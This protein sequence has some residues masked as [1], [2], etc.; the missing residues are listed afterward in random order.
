MDIMCLQNAADLCS[1]YDNC[2]IDERTAL[3]NR[4]E[5]QTEIMADR[6]ATMNSLVKH[7]KTGDHQHLSEEEVAEFKKKILEMVKK[8]GE[9]D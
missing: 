5:E 7:L 2:D 1:Y 9:V 6:I 8:D 3:L 4:F